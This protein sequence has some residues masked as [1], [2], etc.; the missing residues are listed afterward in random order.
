M[1]EQ[2]YHK[3]FGGSCSQTSG[4]SKHFGVFIFTA[5]NNFGVK[6]PIKKIQYN[7]ER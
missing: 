4:K 3:G 6:A 2:H 1:C 5:L 7:S